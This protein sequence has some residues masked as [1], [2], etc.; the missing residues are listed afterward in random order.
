MGRGTE[1]VRHGTRESRG[2]RVESHAGLRSSVFTETV[3]LS[4]LVPF[5]SFLL[6]CFCLLSATPRSYPSAPCI[7]HV[8]L[9]GRKKGH[10][11]LPSR[12]CISPTNPIPIHHRM[13]TSAFHNIASCHFQP[14]SPRSSAAPSPLNPSIPSPTRKG[15]HSQADRTATSGIR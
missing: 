11:V 7:S 14:L 8:K 1:W 5:L 15:E 3:S 13:L 2:K 12:S 6:S 10:T 9:K 4:S